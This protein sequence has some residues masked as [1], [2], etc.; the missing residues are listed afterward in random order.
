[1]IVLHL[2]LVLLVPW[3][4]KSYPGL[5]LFPIGVVDYFIVYGVIKLVEKV[6]KRTPPPQTT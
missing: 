2:L 5:I 4:S 1:M 3:T 6:A